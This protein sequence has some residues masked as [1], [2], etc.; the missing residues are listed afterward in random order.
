MEQYQ[1]SNE[2]EQARTRYQLL[3]DAF[4]ETGN[5]FSI[6]A[7]TQTLLEG[8]EREAFME[9]IH[10]ATAP[11]TDKKYEDILRIVNEHVH[12]VDTSGHYPEY[13]NL[14]TEKVQDGTGTPEE[15][16]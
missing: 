12:L 7:R 8:D 4:G 9:A 3:F 13:G 2:H 1:Q 16:E 6:I 10:A 14:D 11:G 15:R 5:V